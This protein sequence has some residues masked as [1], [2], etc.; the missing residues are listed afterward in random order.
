MEEPGG[1]AGP[2][3]SG[4]PPLLPGCRAEAALTLPVLGESPERWNSRET[5]SWEG[6]PATSCAQHSSSVDGILPIL[7]MRTLKCQ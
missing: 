4:W 5:R 1:Q 6:L 7:Q 3:S 2:D